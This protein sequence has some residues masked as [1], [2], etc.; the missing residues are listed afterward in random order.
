M[1]DKIKSLRPQF[2]GKTE[3]R[4][5]LRRIG[6][7]KKLAITVLTYSPVS[8]TTAASDR[9]AKEI[10]TAEAI[11]RGAASDL[12]TVLHGAEIKR[13]ATDSDGKCRAIRIRS[14]TYYFAAVE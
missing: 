1:N 2:V 7:S 6:N 3:V 11:K 12:C 10:A 4:A 13:N 14:A 9:R 8:V 5:E